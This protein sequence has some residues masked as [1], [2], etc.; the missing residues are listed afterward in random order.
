M[1][2]GD[3][4]KYTYNDGTGTTEQ[5][6]LVTAVDAPGATIWWVD[7]DGRESWNHIT[8]LEVVNESR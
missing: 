7:T 4:V 8:C 1:K 5:L 2:V 6:G 3:L